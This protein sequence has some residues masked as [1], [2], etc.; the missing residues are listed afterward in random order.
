MQLGNRA[1]NY[2][3][4][5][6]ALHW[7]TAAAV[8]ALYIIG[9]GYGFPDTRE[10]HRAAIGL[11][12]SIAMLAWIFLLARIIWYFAQKEPPPPDQHWSLAL[13]SRIVR[14]GLLLIIAVQIVTGPLM[15]W[16][17]ARPIPVFDWFMI[18]S[19]FSVSHHEW[20]EMIEPIHTTAGSLV[21][22]FVGLH[23]LGALKHL[24][25]DRDRIFQRILWVRRAD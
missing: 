18:P 21:L 24:I 17:E 3:W 9:E 13:L 10:G 19:P 1:D 16:F 25:I 20:H 8:I 5:T 15:I 14:Y 22:P 11:H 12:I 23:V 2:G 7:I 6:I 4:V